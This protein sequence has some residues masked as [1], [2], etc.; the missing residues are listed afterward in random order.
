M[1]RENSL[2]LLGPSEDRTPYLLIRSQTL[3]DCA[4]GSGMTKA[5]QLMAMGLKI[6]SP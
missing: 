2:T 5:N 4:T 3:I 6:W 1:D